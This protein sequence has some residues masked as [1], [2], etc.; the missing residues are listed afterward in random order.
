M[1]E[2]EFQEYKCK[3]GGSIIHQRWVVSAAH[4]VARESIFRRG[5][6]DKEIIKKHLRI[7]SGLLNRDRADP[8][9]ETR[10]IVKV[11]IHES[12]GG[13]FS[14]KH[15]VALLQVRPSGTMML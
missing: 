2:S 7:V 1:K 10:N 9:P 5:S 12:W 8:L 15:D 13:W 3:C 4:C 6:V 14:M 11:V